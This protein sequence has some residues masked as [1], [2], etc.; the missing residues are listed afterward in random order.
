MLRVVWA[1]RHVRIRSVGRDPASGSAGRASPEPHLQ[2]QGPAGR[3]QEE[4]V[5]AVVVEVAPGEPGPH[6][7]GQLRGAV[8]DE[9]AEAVEPGREPVEG[10]LYLV[11]L[12]LEL[13]PVKGE[14]AETATGSQHAV[15]AVA[16]GLATSVGSGKGRLPV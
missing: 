2:A 16:A 3:N 5:V 6:V 4:V 7:F 10:H 14:A 1:R 15:G 9:R 12:W 13:A 11:K 8:A